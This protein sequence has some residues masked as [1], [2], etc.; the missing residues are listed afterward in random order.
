LIAFLLAGESGV[1]GKSGRA[2]GYIC[3]RLLD[4]VTTRA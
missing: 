2:A 1:R 3:I 4:W